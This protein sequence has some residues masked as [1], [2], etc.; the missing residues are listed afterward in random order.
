MSTAPRAAVEGAIAAVRRALLASYGWTH[1]EIELVAI[2]SGRVVLGGVVAAPRAIARLRTAIAA[3]LP[4]VRVETDAIAILRS[5]AFVELPDGVTPLWRRPD[6]ERPSELATQLVAEDGPVEAL[7]QQGD[8]TL[9][10]ALDGTLGWTRAVLGP[11]C[12][13]PR[14]VEAVELACE[15]LPALAG[16]WQGTPYRL[17][18]TLPEG[19][20][21][22]GLV[23]RLLGSIGALVPRHSADQLAIAPTEGDGSDAGDIVALWSS[24]EAPCHVG[25]AL[26][27]DAIVHA[28]R[29]RGCV[30]IDERAAWRDRAQ[31]LAHVPLAAIAELQR[32]AAGRRGLGDVLPLGRD[33]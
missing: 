31:R 33:E 4:Y 15:R 1:L 25:L 32:R 11:S 16:A 21:C 9:V 27:D 19:V 3:A 2:E 22:S 20:D 26:G 23:Q 30:V 10:R 7:A 29:S 13:A 28:S 12:A 24:D 5:D 14:M 8:A 6:G 17:G 18:G